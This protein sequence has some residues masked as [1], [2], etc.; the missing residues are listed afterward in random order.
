M[1]D[2]EPL[3]E[4]RERIHPALYVRAS[5][6]VVVV[7]LAGLVGVFGYVM[8]RESKQ[9]DAA[10]AS[11][12]TDDSAVTVAASNQDKLLS[13]VQSLASQQSAENAWLKAHHIPVPAR[14]TRVI[15]VPVLQPIPGHTSRSFVPKRHHSAFHR[16]HRRHRTRTTTTTT[17]TKHGKGH[18]KHHRHH[19]PKH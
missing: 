3:L 17:T 9:L 5:L 19:R 13:Y 4:T 6:I 1:I 12:R 15:H 8:I 18:H 10:L 7:L 11:L 2:V 16:H 14:F